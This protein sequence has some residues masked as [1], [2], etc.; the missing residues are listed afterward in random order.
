MLRFGAFLWAFVE[1]SVVFDFVSVALALLSVTFIFLSFASVLPS[2]ALVSIRHSGSSFRHFRLSIRRSDSSFRH[3]RLSIL[4]FGSSFRRS[5]FYP[6]LSFLQKSYCHHFI[7]NGNS[8]SIF[9]QCYTDGKVLGCFRLFRMHTLHE[10][11][12]ISWYFSI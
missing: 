11:I 6:S 12:D 7:S 5:S 9:I 2:V 3:F 1:L 8:L 4:R 10:I